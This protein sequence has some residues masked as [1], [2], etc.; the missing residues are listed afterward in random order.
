MDHNQPLTT[1]LKPPSAIRSQAA[2]DFAR[3]AKS[4]NTR[5][6]YQAGW[7][8]FAEQFCAD[9]DYQPLPATPETIVEFITWSSDHRKVSTI[10]ARLAAISFA[11]RLAGQPDPT[12]DNEVRLVMMRLRRTKGTKPESK[13]PLGDHDLEKVIASLPHT[14]RGARD[15]ALLLMGYS[16][17]LRRS[18]IA[19]LTVADVRFDE[20]ELVVTLLKRKTDQYG[21][22]TA[23]VVTQVGGPLCAVTALREWLRESGLTEGPV[24][25]SIDRWDHLAGQWPLDGKSIARIIQESAR[26]AGLDPQLFSGHSLRAGIIT[27][28]ADHDVPEHRIRQVSGHRSDAFYAYI[29]DNGRGGRKAIET[30]L[31]SA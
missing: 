10:E 7:R 17:A 15:K 21:H 11:H 27:S 1:T 31:S 12:D 28:A 16:R 29:R 3:A 26:N 2:M 9:L 18:E 23:I 5:K 14:L 13:N 20:N 24:F 25:R 30:V 19:A 22:R 8:I 6:A 4:E